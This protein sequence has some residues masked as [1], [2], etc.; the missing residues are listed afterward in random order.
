M[1]KDLE[2]YEVKAENIQDIKNLYLNFHYNYDQ[3]NPRNNIVYQEFVKK[4]GDIKSIILGPISEFTSRSEAFVESLEAF[5]GDIQ[6][7]ANLKTSIENI[8]YKKK[9]HCE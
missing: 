4:H 2:S 1:T 8:E 6:E 5:N 3:M 9:F 7:L